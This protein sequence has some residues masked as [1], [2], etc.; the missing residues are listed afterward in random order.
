[1][2]KLNSQKNN[3]QNG[4]ALFYA[5][6]MISVISAI[7]FGLASITY[8]QKNLA[9]LAYDSQVAFYAADAGMECALYKN[10]EIFSSAS[11]IDCYDISPDKFSPPSTVTLNKGS[12]NTIWS[13]GSRKESCFSVEL[14]IPTLPDR[15]S[16]SVKGYNT[17][18]PNAVRYVERNLRAFF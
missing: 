11:S 9:S 13:I 2:K 1:M 8:K 17:C 14:I 6:I 18:T 4:F 12:T 5:I 16:F 3:I 15:P 10:A 7:A